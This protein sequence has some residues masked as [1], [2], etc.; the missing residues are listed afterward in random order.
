MFFAFEFFV[1]HDDINF[2]TQDR[3]FLLS[4]IFLKFCLH[5][6][7]SEKKRK[8]NSCTIYILWRYFSCMK[9]KAYFWTQRKFWKLYK[10]SKAKQ[11]QLCI[12]SY[13][14]YLVNINFS[15]PLSNVIK[16]FSRVICHIVVGD[17][18]G[19]YEN[20]TGTKFSSQV[21]QTSVIITY[22]Q[23]GFRIL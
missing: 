10:F 7:V 3:K 14:S 15:P 22:N 16:V 20:E 13:S 12:T 6:Y 18:S 4:V 21:C 2:V 8:L 5:P 9:F 17:S 19:I 11:A 23:R 1:Y